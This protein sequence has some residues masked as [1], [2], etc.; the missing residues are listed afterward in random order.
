M[1]KHLL[2]YLGLLT[3]TSDTRSLAQKERYPLAKIHFTFLTSTILLGAYACGG[4]I[5]LYS[6]AA[7]NIVIFQLIL[8]DMRK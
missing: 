6:L 1:F 4:G 7:V 5:T 3:G 8:K 2:Q